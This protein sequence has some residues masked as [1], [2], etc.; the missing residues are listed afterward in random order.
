VNQV[1]RPPPFS[2][3]WFALYFASGCWTDSRR[4]YSLNAY[5]G[6]IRAARIAGNVADRTQVVETTTTHVAMSHEFAGDMP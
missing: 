2:S 4:I 1:K 3:R 6:E 5:L